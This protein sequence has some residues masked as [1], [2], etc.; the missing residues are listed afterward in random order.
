MFTNVYKKSCTIFLQIS[1]MAGQHVKI[2]ECVLKQK[3]FVRALLTRILLQN[4]PNSN[5][6]EKRNRSQQEGF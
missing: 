4:V 6:L 1:I 5:C 2:Y 3:L